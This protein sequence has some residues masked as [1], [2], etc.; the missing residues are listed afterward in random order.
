MPQYAHASLILGEDRSKLSKRHGATSVDQFKQQG[1]LKEAMINYLAAL[2]WNDGTDKE[3]YTVGEIVEGFDVERVNSSPSMFDMTK[4]KWVNGQHIRGMEPSAIAPMVKEQLAG[5]ELLLAEEGED[6]EEGFVDLAVANTQDK[7]EVLTEAVD[8]VE[9]VLGFQ[10]DD[11]AASKQGA[12][13][14]ED[15]FGAL[16]A[17]IVA[18]FD[19]GE[20]PTGEGGDAEAFEAAWKDWVKALGKSLGRKGKRLFM[21]IRLAVTGTMSGGD[22]GTQLRLVAAADGVVA[23]E[24]VVPLAQRIEK[25]RAL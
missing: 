23:P 18:A 21:P 4:L 3:I 6:I 15:E 12:A 11:T 17:A 19:A 2:G 1:L 5:S 13:I 10:F 8:L 25:L 22:I 7:I 14:V 24:K 9:E 20:M 16:A